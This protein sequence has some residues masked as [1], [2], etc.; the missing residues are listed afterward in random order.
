MSEFSEIIES[1]SITDTHPT[2]GELEREVGCNVFSEDM[3]HQTN[4]Q[5]TTKVLSTEN[6]ISGCIQ[7]HTHTHRQSK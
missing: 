1:E 3:V 5:T 7:T 2:K 4:K 6:F